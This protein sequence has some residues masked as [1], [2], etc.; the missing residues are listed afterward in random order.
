MCKHIHVANITLK[1]KITDD[2]IVVK[3]EI[4]AETGKILNNDLEDIFKRYFYPKGTS[5]VRCINCDKILEYTDFYDKFCEARGYHTIDY[6]N[7]IHIGP[8]NNNSRMTWFLKPS[9]VKISLSGDILNSE[10]KIKDYE[11]ISNF[12]RCDKCFRRVV[13]RPVTFADILPCVIL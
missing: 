9:S 11:L 1:S 7:L 8:I 10:Y 3:I 5:D 4:D 2:K 12:V 6:S 13:L